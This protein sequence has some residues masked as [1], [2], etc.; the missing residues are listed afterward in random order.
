MPDALL[1]PPRSQIVVNP[2]RAT[3]LTTVFR[4]I[5]IIANNVAALP[6][7]TFRIDTPIDNPLIVNHPNISTTRRD[8]LYQTVSSLASWGEAFWFKQFDE[9]NRT[10]NITVLHPQLVTVTQ[11]DYGR[12]TY[13]YKDVKYTSNE[14][15]HLKLFS[16][17]GTL[18][19]VGPI[20]AC[21]ED[22]QASLDLRGYAAGWFGQAGVPTGVLTSNAALNST[23]AAELRQ[24]WLDIHNGGTV[25]VLGNGFQYSPVAIS[26]K[27]AMFVE[28]MQFN[29]QEIG[30]LFGVPVSFL[31]SGVEGSSNTYVNREEEVR[32]FL[33]NTIVGY[34][35]VIQDALSD[36]LPRGQ[37]VQFKFDG[38]LKTNLDARFNAYST[39][40]NAG[41]MTVNE[42]RASEGMTPLADPKPQQDKPEP[43]KDMPKPDGS[44]T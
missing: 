38:L 3:S 6:L 14:I 24:R 36:A 22:I 28:V 11:D 8:F 21:R 39:A 13:S 44:V 31:E 43:E 40:I 41:F 32:N 29:V 19:G 9:Y 37:R 25:A 7:Q 18:R 35:D 1:P 12:I 17:T 23:Q 34:T 10:I 16:S 2:D 5:Q 42:V 30:R 27:D 33:N 4:S 26:P 15:A 20:Q